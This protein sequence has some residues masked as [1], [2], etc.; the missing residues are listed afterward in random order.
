MI[1]VY[2]VGFFASLGMGGFAL[3]RIGRALTGRLDPIEIEHFAGE[4]EDDPEHAL[5]VASNDR[6]PSSWSR[7]AAPWRS[8]C[9]SPSRSWSAASR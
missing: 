6:S 2:G 3:A 1:W 7:S 5:K 8:E 4:Y 9:R